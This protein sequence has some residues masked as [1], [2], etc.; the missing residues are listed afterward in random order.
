MEDADFSS[1][2]T[3]EVSNTDSEPKPNS[4]P[5]KRPRRALE[6]AKEAKSQ[7]STSNTKLFVPFRALG[8]V[9]NHIPFVIQTRSFKGATDGPRV[10]ILTCLGRSWALWE[11]GKMTLLFVGE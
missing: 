2:A 1:M 10:H 9:T 5:R 7:P 6:E 4:R 11:G 8:L 3:L